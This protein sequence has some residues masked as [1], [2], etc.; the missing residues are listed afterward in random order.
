M[1]CL[2][3]LYS[4]KFFKGC[5]PQILIG[6]FFEYFVSFSSRSQVYWIY[7]QVDWHKLTDCIQFSF[8]F[9]KERCD[10][11]ISLGIFTVKSF[12]LYRQIFLKSYVE[13]S[14]F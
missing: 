1:V 10:T 3:R 6:P 5:L 8:L 11:R 7:S 4:S 9:L 14:N 2:S 13:F 12:F